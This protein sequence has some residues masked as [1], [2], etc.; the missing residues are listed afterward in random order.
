M[1]GVKGRSGGKRP[2]TGGARP[3]AGRK[4][5]PPIE[6]SVIGEHEDPKVFL[7]AVMNDTTL[8]GK[9]RLD[10]AKALMPYVHQRLAEG[11]KKDARHDAARKV[12]KG[13]F[14]PAAAPRLVV[15]NK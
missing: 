13:K 2:N 9:V 1:A 10:A 14:A 8:D 6:I 3:G 15:S 11:G 7:L 4:P 5:N 12:S